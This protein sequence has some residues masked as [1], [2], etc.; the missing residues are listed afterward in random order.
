[1]AL[2]TAISSEIAVVLR[3]CFLWI[4]IDGGGVDFEME[5]P[6][7]GDVAAVEFGGGKFP[8]LGGFQGAVGE[9][10]AG[11]GSVERRFGYVT[12]FVDVDFDGEANLA[13]DCVS[14]FLRGVGQDLLNDFAVH[15]ATSGCCRRGFDT[16]CRRSGRARG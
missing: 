7:A 16:G 1:M 4:D 15:N 14:G 3:S 12:R 8:E 5:E 10:L 9:I 6:V 2:M 11:A 13:V